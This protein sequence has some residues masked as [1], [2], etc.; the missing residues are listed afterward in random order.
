MQLSWRC[1]Q[2]HIHLMRQLGWTICG[3]IHA[4][5]KIVFSSPKRAYWLWGPP[6][7]PCNVYRGSFPVG[8][9][10]GPLYLTIHPHLYRG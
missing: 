3:S 2:T 7:L 1:A 9:A 8:R 6:S 5:G 10:S 4:R